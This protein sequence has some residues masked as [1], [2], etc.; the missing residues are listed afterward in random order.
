[1]NLLPAV[2]LVCTLRR[3]RP[4]TLVLESLRNGPPHPGTEARITDF[5]IF[6]VVLVSTGLQLKVQHAQGIVT[7][8]NA[9]RGPSPKQIQ[10]LKR[11]HDTARGASNTWEWS[12]LWSCARTEGKSREPRGASS[13]HAAKD[14][15]VYRYKENPH[16]HPRV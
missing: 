3:H 11:R 2:L 12:C 5:E 6:L 16:N 9:R 13:E 7:A 4:C 10:P 1:M 8:S 15:S 14:R